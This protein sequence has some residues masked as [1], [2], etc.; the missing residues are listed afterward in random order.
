MYEDME[1]DNGV[2]YNTENFDEDFSMFDDHCCD[3]CFEDCMYGED[4][5]KH[6][7]CFADCK[8]EYESYD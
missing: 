7:Q 8:K 6:C 3:G 5:S 1:T 4:A 2:A